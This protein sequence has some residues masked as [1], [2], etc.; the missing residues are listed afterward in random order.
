MTRQIC[1]I[2][3][4]ELRRWIP[5]GY[6]PVLHLAAMFGLGAAA[7]AWLAVADIAHAPLRHLLLVPALL[8]GASLLEYV[9]HR[10]VMHARHRLTEPAWAAH[11]GRH[12]HY[13][14]AD[15]PTWD[16][17]RD[18]WLILFSPI[19]VVALAAIVGG[20]L[21]LLWHLVGASDGALVV[22]TCVAY[23]LAYEALHLTF[24]LPDGHPLLR[25]RALAAR[26]A[27][28]LRHHQLADTHANYAVVLPL[29]DRVFGTARG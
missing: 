20:P 25:V 26:R 14:R 13:Y 22:A 6:R 11:V 17:A 8:L 27:H 2:D 10:W 21:A 15:A 28:H 23:F 7:I 29:W 24:H 4:D 18:I 16:R 12:H 3:R 1:T 9:A 5:A 19:D